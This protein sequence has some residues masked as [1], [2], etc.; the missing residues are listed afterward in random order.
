MGVT[1]VT[2]V[3]SIRIHLMNEIFLFLDI[4]FRTFLSNRFVSRSI[5]YQ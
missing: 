3:C 2:D 4:I 5:G 1:L